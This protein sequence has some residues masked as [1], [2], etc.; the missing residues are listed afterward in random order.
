MSD[1]TQAAVVNALSLALVLPYDTSA[2]GEYTY[3][4]SEDGQKSAK[5]ARID[6]PIRAVGPEWSAEHTQDEEAQRRIFPIHTLFCWFRRSA[7][8][9]VTVVY[10]QKAGQCLDSVGPGRISPSGTANWR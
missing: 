7:A 1:T 8:A 2:L 10:V 6:S 9:V 3:K 5:G 4:Q